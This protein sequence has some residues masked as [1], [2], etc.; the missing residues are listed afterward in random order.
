MVIDD[1]QQHHD[2]VGVG[3]I[4]KGLEVF[5]RAILSL[6]RELQNAVITPAA[7]AREG[8]QRHEFDNRHTDACEIFKLLRC[9][10]K[11]SLFC[12]SSDMKLIDDRFVPRPAFQVGVFPAEVMVDD[13]GGAERAFV[14]A[15]RDAGLSET[16]EV[17]N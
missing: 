17:K 10:R 15:W 16:W 9:G 11:C 8:R 4:Y 14:P 1:I 6:G 7:T 3:L 12:K 2:A 5:G 13:K